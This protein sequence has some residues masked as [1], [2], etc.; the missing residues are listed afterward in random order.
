MHYAIVKTNI[1]N[2][3]PNPMQYKIYVCT[4][5]YEYVHASANLL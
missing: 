3:D 2:S 4:M 1:H 5:Y